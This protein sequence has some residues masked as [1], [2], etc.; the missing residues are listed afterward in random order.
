MKKKNGYLGICLALCL[1]CPVFAYGQQEIGYSVDPHGDTLYLDRIGAIYVFNKPKDTKSKDWLKYYKTVYNFNKAYPFALTAARK[2]SWADSLL[3]AQDY[4]ARQREKV[5]RSIEKALFLE[6]EKPLRKLTITQ[7]A[8][9]MRLIDREVGQSTYY[10]IKGYRGGTTAGVWQGVAK[11][12]GNNLKT[13]YDR[14]GED[15]LLEELVHMYQQGSFYYLYA[16]LFG[17]Q[18]AS[19]DVRQVVIVQRPQ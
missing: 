9:L 17:S 2:I 3:A 7:G 14:Y 10:I 6:F 8:M 11:L 1:L 12:F 4:T 13:P 15:Q 18:R 19:Q 5:I 16:S